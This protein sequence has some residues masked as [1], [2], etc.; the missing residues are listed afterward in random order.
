MQLRSSAIAPTD[1]AFAEKAT[2][3]RFSQLLLLGVVVIA[4][5]VRLPGL[6]LPLERDEGAYAFVAWTWLRGDLPYRDVFDH[7]PPLIYL[8]YMPALLFGAPSALVLRVWM[9]VLFVID[10]VLVYAIG[11]RVWDRWSALLAA[12]IFAVA[13]SAFSLQ[14]MIFN[15]EQALVLPALIAL[16]YTIRL[17]ETARLRFA[18]GAGAAV[19]ATVLIKPVALVL[20][21]CILLACR[22]ELRRLAQVIGAA[23]LGGALIGLPI[24]TYFAVRGGWR[25]MIFAL[26]TYNKLYA[27]ESQARWELGALVDM[28][29]PFVPLL[30][31]AIGGM[32]LLRRAQ[33]AE[34]PMVA[35][36][37]GWLV[38][39]WMLAFFVTALGSLRAF[40]HYYYALLPFLAL[41]AAPC[42]VWLWRQSIG[43]TRLQRGV[44]KLA[45][46]LVLAL[47]I[48]PFARQNI[49]L[50]GTTGEQQAE[51]LYGPEGLYYF[52]QAARVADFVRQ[53]TQPGDYI[54][55][56]GAEPE[57][58]LLAERRNASRY[59][60]DYPIGLVPGAKEQL[61]RDLAA[62]PPALL[63]AYYGVRPI[64][65]IRA[66]D[67]LG[68]E[69]IA[70][71]GGYEIFGP[72]A[73][74]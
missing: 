52:A 74:R 14:G 3:H 66:K 35:R 41:L 23:T 30:L 44:R 18:V 50:I 37:S 32:M 61:L 22:R 9:S 47:L 38:V 26:V 45:P 43:T 19:A 8:L 56:F 40:V 33:R 24:A 20:A 7:K 58:Y 51:R 39:A 1:V 62:N 5:L 16:W 34:R 48:V 11:R 21:P 46:V 10:V 65:L 4:I 55:I 60:F 64:E 2:T 70:E 25:A 73:A 15:T 42:V 36:S 13:G 71:I 68:F 31:V 59:I 54:H 17:H 49:G 72:P 6:A 29:T 69:K 12:L 63:I 27:E 53:Q 57:V 67:A 28:F